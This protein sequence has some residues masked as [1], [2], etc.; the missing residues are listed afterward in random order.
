MEELRKSLQEKEQET[1]KLKD[2]LEDLTKLK[3]AHENSLIEK[4]SLLLNEKK[5]K[6]RDQQRLLAGATVD[7]ARLEA[8]EQSRSNARSRSPGPSRIGK[9]KVGNVVKDD[10]DTDDGFEKMEVDEPDDSDVDDRRTPDPDS[11]ADEA[12]DDDEPAPPPTKSS[13]AVKNTN[14]RA[15]RSAT[16]G[17]ASALPPKREL[18]FAAKK[19]AP[20]AKPADGSETES[21]ED[22]EL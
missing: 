18:P 19:A 4:F 7:P 20:P 5:L 14:T 9:R 15:T 12:S 21:D 16:T 6:I 1:K 10:N 11:T 13:N 2:E 8:I 22:D 17:E 3:N